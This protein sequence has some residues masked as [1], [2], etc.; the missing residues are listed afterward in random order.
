[1]SIVVGYIPTAE[2]KAAL[3]RAIDET[4][5]RHTNLVVLN[6]SR[7]DAYADPKYAQEDELRRIGEHL[8]ESGVQYELRQF[9]R[10][11][12]AAEEVVDLAA[13]LDAELVVIGIRHRTAVGKLLLG[14]TAQR[15]LLDAEC[16]VLAV[17]APHKH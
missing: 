11:K 8:D 5:L 15:I 3:E 16:P 9:V 1:M 2:G 6:S 13:E 14:S 17:K 12:D 10:G 7:G 4:K